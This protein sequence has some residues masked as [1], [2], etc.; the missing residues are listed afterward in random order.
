VLAARLGISA[1]EWAAYESGQAIPAELAIAFMAVTRCN[2]R[3]LWTGEGPKFQHDL[4][5]NDG[6]GRGANRGVVCDEPPDEAVVPEAPAKPSHDQLKAEIAQLR[7]MIDAAIRTPPQR[8][9]ER[10][11]RE[12]DKARDPLSR[13]RGFFTPPPNW[14]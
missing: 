5:I 4:R 8:E 2:P 7:A 13:P 14:P 10:R 3:W 1:W 9:Q 6:G 12:A 11:A